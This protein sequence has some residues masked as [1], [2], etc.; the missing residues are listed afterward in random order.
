MLLERLDSG[1]L[2]P[3]VT[4]IG[5]D[6]SAAALG[7]VRMSGSI[8]GLCPLGTV[9]THTTPWLWQHKCL[10]VTPNVPR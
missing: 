3:G 4:D 6:T 1:F 8:P 9:S 7:T 10:R 5:P 2:D